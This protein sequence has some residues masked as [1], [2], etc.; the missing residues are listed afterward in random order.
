MSHLPLFLIYLSFYFSIK[1]SLQFSNF[2]CCVS[3]GSLFKL[4]LSLNSG[5]NALSYLF[6]LKEVLFNINN[7]MKEN[8]ETI[9]ISRE[10]HN[11]RSQ[12]SSGFVFLPKLSILCVRNATF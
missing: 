4:F 8:N 7:V 10:Y 1:H 11:Q 12:P 3:K 2:G 6:D 5:G 9:S